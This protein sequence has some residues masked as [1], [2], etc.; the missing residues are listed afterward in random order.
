MERCLTTLV[1]LSLTKQAGIDKEF[2]QHFA[3]RFQTF[4]LML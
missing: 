3:M 1:R 4:A 2:T